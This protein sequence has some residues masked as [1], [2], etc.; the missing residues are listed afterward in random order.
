MIK[1][2]YDVDVDYCLKLNPNYKITHFQNDVLVIDDWYENFEALQKFVYEEGRPTNWSN[3]SDDYFD[4]K[5]YT[6][7]RTGE[8]A[9]INGIKNS[10]REEMMTELLKLIKKYFNF[11]G[12]FDEND[13]LNFNYFK[14]FKKQ[15]INLHHY[16]H[17]DQSDFGAVIFL[18]NI[19]DGG[20]QFYNVVETKNEVRPFLIDTKTHTWESKFEPIT[21]IN[22]KP[23]RLVIG[24]TGM[25]NHGAYFDDINSYLNDWRISQVY[26]IV[27]ED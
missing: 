17:T 14:L 10:N 8:K 15:E 19:C 18:D 25:Q 20:L 5:W 4:G 16:P 1:P 27:G 3:G 6:T 9:R 21:T 24:R 11:E 2:I 7:H 26:F 22:S 12:K 23:N 13:F